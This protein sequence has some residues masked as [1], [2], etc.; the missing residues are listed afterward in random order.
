M[1][2]AWPSWGIWIIKLWEK[3]PKVNVNTCENQT[4]VESN[5]IELSNYKIKKVTMFEDVIW[6][7]F[8]HNELENW[9]FEFLNL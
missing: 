2:F 1:V 7:V 9:V 4:L 8:N 6:N 5:K 3:S